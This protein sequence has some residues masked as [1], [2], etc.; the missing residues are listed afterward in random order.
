MKR[1]QLSKASQLAIFRRDEWLC[2]WCRKPVIFAPVMKLMELEVRTAGHTGPLAY[3]HAH[4]TRATSPL[5]DE[6][7]AMLDHVT[8]FAIGG[9][10]SEENIVAACAKCNSCKSSYTV[11]EWKT[12]LFRRTIKGKYG[13]PKVWDGLSSMFLI[14]AERHPSKLSTTDREWVRA[15]KRPIPPGVNLDADNR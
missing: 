9:T 7:G 5:L 6:L 11:E 4:W 2:H 8:A 1:A 13:E 12:R 3:Y 15:M 14:L 10:C